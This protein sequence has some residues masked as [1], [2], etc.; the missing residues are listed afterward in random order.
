MHHW[1]FKMFSTHQME[2]SKWTS[3]RQKCM[4][5]GLLDNGDCEV[6]KDHGGDD[7][8]KEDDD[9]VHN[10]LGKIESPPIGD[11]CGF[12]VDRNP[13][14]P[15]DKNEIAKKCVRSVTCNKEDG[16]IFTVQQFEVESH[17]SKHS[18]GDKG[19]KREVLFSEVNP[20]SMSKMSEE[21][22]CVKALQI[23]SSLCIEMADH[24]WEMVHGAWED[25]LG[26]EF[27][28]EWPNHDDVRRIAAFRSP[29]K[30]E[31][32]MMQQ[33]FTN[34]LRQNVH[35][36]KQDLKTRLLFQISPRRFEELHAD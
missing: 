36:S 6:D 18:L 9:D 1:L 34:V 8:H 28:D 10:I 2:F 26:S 11:Q 5:F 24:G 7:D 14:I 16:D 23:R 21:L 12:R 3:K 22:G 32:D 17:G 27:R 13:L 19:N 33:K 4:Q 20:L 30:K 31:K 25:E 15:H 29:C 35:H